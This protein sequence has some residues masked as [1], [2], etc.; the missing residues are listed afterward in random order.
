MTRAAVFAP[1]A[2][3]LVV[4]VGLWP[5]PVVGMLHAEGSAVIAALSFF[6][7]GVSAVGAFARGESVR[8]VSRRHLA[9]LVVPWALL[10]ATVLWRPNCGYWL[11]LGLFAVLVPPS[12]LLGIAVA[13][14]AWAFGLWRQ[15]LVVVGVGGLLA[16]VPTLVTLKLHPQLFVYNVIYG[17]VLG[18]VYDAELALR[19]GLLAHRVLTL[20]WTAWG[21]SL[22]GWM[23]GEGKA[24]LALTSVI[25]IGYVFSTP[26]G[27]TQSQNGI[28]AVLFVRHVT[29]R[30]VLHSAPEAVPTARLIALGTEIEYRLDRLEDALGVAPEAPVD[31]YLYPDADTKAALIGS[32]E[33]SV[34]PVWLGS[35]Q[36]HLLDER[37]DGDLGHELV[38]VVAREFG[39]AITHATLK[40]GLVEGLAV[41]LEPP[42]GLP[43]P[44]QQTAVALTL[45]P[46]AG[47]L[48]DPAAAVR[49]AMNPWA[50]WT[51]RAGVAYSTTGAFVSWLLDAHGPEPLRAVYGG[52]DWREAYGQPL[53]PLAEAW[54]AD[55]ADVER[56]PEA[57]VFTAW[58]FGQPSL[59]EVR[60]PHHVPDWRRY[61][62]EADAAWEAGD[63]ARVQRFDRLAVD[64]APEDP[65]TRGLLAT[66]AERVPMLTEPGDTARRLAEIVARDT[67]SLVEPRIALFRA[68]SLARSPEASGALD[69]ALA[70]LPPFALRSS[71]LLRLEASLSA[72]TLRLLLSP[73]ADSI[74]TVRHARRVAPDSASGVF[75]AALLYAEA[76][77]PARAWRM[78]REARV[79]GVRESA[80]G[81]EY[82]A[83]V[84]LML[85]S[86]ALRAGDVE[87]AQRLARE[88]ERAFVEAGREDAARLAAD[89]VRKA[90][91]ASEQDR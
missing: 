38:H 13:R 24:P 88:A 31:V 70:A 76:G 23:R 80:G 50:F 54:A 58:R 42:D 34:V 3:Y 15:R 78:G 8:A 29:P 11:G 67:A 9:L 89:A 16:L 40:I 14:V 37:A 1:A 84:D 63:I 47:G 64:A 35:P 74:A 85:A 91:W 49:A 86:L 79:R 6:V 73:R 53:G 22:A 57:E 48:T 28:E 20:V 66:R 51:G 2:V 17:G 18:P 56:S 71:A 7:A 81:G 82:A 45:A 62:R 55:L 69:S 61:T 52:A 83:S 46:E 27:I 26:L 72:E 4:G 75:F 77:D 65:L 43:S 44:T 30:A 60:C 68:R 36:V 90:E 59:F 19:P 32:R 12:T 10:T 5:V 25:A 21:V 33:T 39:Q 87:S 41:A